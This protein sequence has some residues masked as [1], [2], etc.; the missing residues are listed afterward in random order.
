MPQGPHLWTVIAVPPVS[1]LLL[2]SKEKHNHVSESLGACGESVAGED[3][4]G[5]LL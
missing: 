4:G 1:E 2:S 3:R 5:G